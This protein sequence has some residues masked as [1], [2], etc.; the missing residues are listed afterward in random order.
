MSN[1]K[2]QEINFLKHRVE[3]IQ[4]HCDKKIAQAMRIIKTLRN[5]RK[6]T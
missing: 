6:N 2:E 4:N 5:E 1:F 3:A